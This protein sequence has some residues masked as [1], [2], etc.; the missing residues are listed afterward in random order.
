MT[1]ITSAATIEKL[2]E[3][4]AR[5]GLPETIVSDNGGQLTSAEFKNFCSKNGIKH[6]TSAPYQPQSNGAAENAVKSF[7][8]GMSKAF[9]DPK[10]TN[11]SL[12]TLTSRY[13]FNYRSSVH[14]TTLETPFKLM[15]GREMKTHFDQINPK[16]LIEMC[17]VSAAATTKPNT[18]KTTI[19]AS[20]AHTPPVQESISKKVK[21]FSV[22]DR[23]LARDHQS[24][25]HPWRKAI[26]TSVMGNRLYK[27]KTEEGE[28]WRRHADQL[29]PNSSV[30]F[31]HQF[32]NNDF[33]SFS[34]R[35]SI[36][37]APNTKHDVE[38]DA[39]TSRDLPANAGNPDIANE[40]SI[41]FDTAEESNVS[42][43]AETIDTPPA[44]PK[45][46]SARRHS[47]RPSKIP[48]RLNYK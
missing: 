12:E 26:I 27:C 8:I 9:A 19:T 4:F 18:T 5:F 21:T 6:L 36:A 31:S 3:C 38:P 44:M 7:K 29:M 20:E 2:R 41:S 30:K 46:I 40:S 15:F 34:D 43:E 22:N 32:T 42:T 13:L 45:P 11:A 1:A 25:T 23:V 10:N 17:D 35:F 39:P 33:S 47:T 48:E 37:P 16:K 28:C 24:K 14:S